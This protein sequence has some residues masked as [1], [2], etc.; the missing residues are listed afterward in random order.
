MTGCWKAIVNIQNEFSKY[1][2]DIKKYLVSNVRKG[3]NTLFWTYHW[4]EGDALKDRFPRLFQLAK[5]KG[6]KVI[7]CY[8]DNNL[9][10]IWD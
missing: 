10:R 4:I 3:E 8:K 7:E 6:A 9:N 1:G 2:V 5:D